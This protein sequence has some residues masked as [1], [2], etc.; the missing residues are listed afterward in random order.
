MV[1][2]MLYNTEL[3]RRG[4]FWSAWTCS[5]CHG[6]DHPRGLCPFNDLED[7][8]PLSE[9]AIPHPNKAKPNK[10]GRRNN[11]SIP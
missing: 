2:T 4:E 3:H 9:P 6:I 11:R 7:D 5:M 8:V 10:S 1:S